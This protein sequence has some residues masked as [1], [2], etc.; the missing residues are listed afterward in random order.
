MC[1]PA[2][3]VEA[4]KVATPDPFSGDVASV[5]DP[6]ENDAVPV[7][8]PTDALTPAVNVTVCP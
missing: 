1:V 2:P 4:L 8:V 7:G 6:S 5:V 3:R